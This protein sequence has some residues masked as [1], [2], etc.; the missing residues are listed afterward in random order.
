MRFKRTKFH[1]YIW[2]LTKRRTSPLK[3]F[4]F[5]E[6]RTNSQRRQANLQD[7]NSVRHQC[8][9]QTSYQQPTEPAKQLLGCGNRGDAVSLYLWSG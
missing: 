2:K 5:T 4:V 6:K 1:K 7:Q 9:T 8:Y 3:M